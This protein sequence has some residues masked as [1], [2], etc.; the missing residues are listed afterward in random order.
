MITIGVTFKPPPYPFESPW[1]L[2]VAGTIQIIVGAQLARRGLLR[3][4]GSA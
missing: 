4:A 3:R 2:V 1:P